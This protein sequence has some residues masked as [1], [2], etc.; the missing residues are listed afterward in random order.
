MSAGVA[1]TP[2]LETKYRTPAYRVALVREPGVTMEARPQTSS[3][4]SVA[5]LLR[6]FLAD[7]DR[8]H[9]VVIGVDTKNRIIGIHSAHV[10]A[11]DRC[12]VRVA[13]ALKAAIL[14]NAASIIIGHNH[15]SG[16]PEPSQE[17]KALT[18]SFVE[19][20]KCLEIRVL[21]HVIVGD[22]GRY[23]SFREFRLL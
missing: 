8:E 14:M 19:A 11:L 17:D 7:V 1:E 5:A 18:R 21:D 13:D 22:E 3:P 23:F 10:G 15:P 20:C 9:F 2:Q 16:D 12:T 6:E 4:G